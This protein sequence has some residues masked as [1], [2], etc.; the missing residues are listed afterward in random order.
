MV[1][2]TENHDHTG[3]VLDSVNGFD[4]LECVN[5]RFRHIMPI[6]KLDELEGIYSHTYYSEQKPKY[7]EHHIEDLDWWNMTY[8]NRYSTL[9]EL[10]PSNQRRILDVGSGPGY[11]LNVGKQR[12]WQT[13]GIEP[14]KQASKHSS[15]L[16]LEIIND[17]LTKDTAAKLGN[18]HVVHLSEVLEHLPDPKS[19][20]DTVFGI[21]HTGGLAYITVPNDYNPFQ[22]VARDV[23]SINPWWIVPPYHIN[24]FNFDSL[25]NLVSSCGFEIVLRDSSFPIDI[26]LLMGDI[27]VGND[28]LGRKIHNKRK[29]MELNLKKAGMD[30]IKNKLYQ[31]L[32]SI[33]LGRHVEI[34]AR[35]VS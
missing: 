13:V 18:F 31:G 11:F 2:S 32:A 10:L 30:H 29:T 24:Y 1:K 14:S 33:G 12:G 6:P 28:E 16:G 4:V 3:K 17:F 27:Y 8:T 23:N 20:L 5:C 7:I 21:L 22:L 35:K 9:E 34:A 26:F 19:M 25:E 15:S